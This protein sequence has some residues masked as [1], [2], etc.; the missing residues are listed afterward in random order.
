MTSSPKELIYELSVERVRKPTNPELL[1]NI[2]TEVDKIKDIEYDTN[3]TEY[4]W[5]KNKSKLEQLLINLPVI[6]IDEKCKCEEGVFYDK[7]KIINDELKLIDKSCVVVYKGEIQIVYIT[8]EYDK[9]IT[10][11]TEKLKELGEQ[12]NKYHRTKKKSFYSSFKLGA[13]TEEEKEEAHYFKKE[14][15]KDDKYKGSNWLDGLIN[16]YLSPCSHYPDRK[17]GTLTTYQPREWEANNDDDFMFN[18]GYSYCAL[19]ELEKRYAP[20]ITDERINKAKKAEFIGAIPN[21]PLE[22]LAATGLGGSHNFSSVIHSDSGIEGL[23]ETIFWTKCDE[24]KEQYFVSPTIKMYFDLSKHNAII[25]QPPK[26]PHGT[27]DTGEHGGY[28]FVNIT[29]QRCIEKGTNIKSHIAWK[30]YFENYSDDDIERRNIN[31]LLE[32]MRKNKSG[33]GNYVINGNSRVVNEDENGLF[34]TEKNKKYY[35]HHFTRKVEP[36]GTDEEYKNLD[37]EEAYREG[38]KNMYEDIITII[39]NNKNPFTLLKEIEELR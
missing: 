9:A 36:E 14:T 2:F 37:L 18:L 21:I 27:A 39:H 17:Y 24:G 3:K 6:E 33:K 28:G 20:A 22:R 25:L 31:D 26:I 38:R 34:Y 29:K 35:F 16:F 4:K 5:T 19:Q 15:H 30:E 11:A 32:R 1:N 23:T 12:M 10:K 8:E 7:E 13:T